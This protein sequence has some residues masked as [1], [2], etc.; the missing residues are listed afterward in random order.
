MYKIYTFSIKT[1]SKIDGEAINHNDKKWINEKYL[2]KAVGYKNL[3]CNKT[4]YYSDKFKKRRYEI[5]NYED[6]QPCKRFIAEELAVHLIMDI[7][8]VKASE[9]RIKLGFNQLDP[10]MTKQKSIGLRIRKTFPNEETI[11]DFYVKKFDY[12]IDFYL[13]KRK[14]ATEF[15]ELGHKDRKQPKEKIRQKELEKYLA[16]TFIKINPDEKDFNVYDGLC[17]IQTFIDK[18]KDE[19]SEKLKDKIKELKKD[20]ESLIDKISKRLLELRFEKN[21]SIKS[22]CLKWIVKKILPDYK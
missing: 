21:H 15:F 10:I 17:K 3:A 11:E 7:K 13:P 19:E 18:L 5:Q 14:L 1:W 20:K 6:Y 2:E 8:T 16:C 4:Q 9:L 22:K 12:V